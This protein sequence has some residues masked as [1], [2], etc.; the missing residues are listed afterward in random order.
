MGLPRDRDHAIALGQATGATQADYLELN[1]HPS[2]R[3][4]SRGSW[5][6]E[7]SLTPKERRK[8]LRGEEYFPTSHA[9]SARFDADWERL[10]NCVALYSAPSRSA[11]TYASY[12]FGSLVGSWVGRMLIPDENSY[13][14][15]IQDP[16]L[17]RNFSELSPFSTV[18][19]FMLQIMEYHCIDPETPADVRQSEQGMDEGVLNA[20]LPAVKMDKNDV[21][22]FYFLYSL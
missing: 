3:L 20:Y 16:A 4:L 14:T 21:R 10:T 9:L 5:D 12:A 13:M 6:W 18:R 2:A 22:P 17:H 1:A 8:A 19:P 15:M 7:R 11:G